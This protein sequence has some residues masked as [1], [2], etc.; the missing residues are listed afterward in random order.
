V[1]KKLFKMA[2]VLGLL[3]ASHAAYVRTF[4]HVVERLRSTQQVDETD[5]AVH[6]SETKTLVKET[7]ERVF[8]P[9]SWTNSD[10]LLRYVS[11][12]KG[13]ILFA[14]EFS[15]PVES[16]GVK[17]DGKRIEVT[18]AAVVLRSPKGGSTRT[19][20][21]ES[22]TIDFNKPFGLNPGDTEPLTVRYARLERNVMLRD[23]RGTP[24]DPSDDLVIGPLTE[25][26][27]IDDGLAPVIKTDSDVVVVDRN[28]RVTGT[29]L[30]I[31]LRPKLDATRPDG[32]SP[33][34]DGA[35]QL[36]LRKNVRTTFLDVGSTG[37]LPDL[38]ARRAGAAGAAK[39]KPE[40]IPLD[41]QCD[42]PL[43]VALPQTAPAPPVGPPQPA[44]PTYVEFRNNVVVRR[45]KL[46]ELPDQL[47]CDTLHLTLL[48]GE[49]KAEEAA[50]AADAPAKGEKEKDGA[51]GGL[52]LRRVKAS[53][54]AVWLQMPGQGAKILCV[55]LLHYKDPSSGKNT[56]VFNGGGPRKLWVEKA[57]L[58]AAAPAP[59]PGAAP[60]AP[61]SVT[62][63]WCSD[64]TLTDDG[65]PNR[66]TLV[67]NGP[68]LLETRPAPAANEPP[69]DVPPARTATWRDQLWVQ[70][71]KVEEGAVPGRILVLKG[72]P[73]V[74]DRDKGASLESADSIVVWLNPDEKKETTADGREVV[75]AAFVQPDPAAPKPAVPNI[76]RLLAVKDVHLIDPTRDLRLKDRLDVDFEAGT[77]QGSPAA[78]AANPA[79]AAK[80]AAS[81]PAGAPSGEPGLTPVPGPGAAAEKPAGPKMSAQ[82][83]RA[84]AVVAVV[85]AGGPR[86]AAPANS[87]GEPGYELREVE[88]RGAVALHQD[89]GPGKTVGTDAAGEVLILHNRAQGQ[90]VFDLYH[91]DQYSARGR[92]IDPKKAPKARV[93]TEE[94]AIEAD[95]ISVDQ[96][97]D[98]AW[99]Y[100]AGK[101]TQLTDRALF[102]DRSAEGL[103]EADREAGEPAKVRRRA[104]KELSNKVP[105][106]IT[107]A[108]EMNFEGIAKDPED[109]DA[110][111][112]RFVGRAHATMEDSLLYGEDSITVYT[113]KPI[114]LVDA[115][116]LTGRPA[117]KAEGAEPEPKADLSM[118]VV[119]GT[120]TQAAVATTRKVHPDLRL[121]L[122][123]QRLTARSL[124]YDRRTGVF[125]APGPG[126][127]YLYD[128]NS[129]STK[130]AGEAD[131][132][133]AAGPVVT[134]TSYRPG[135]DE[136]LGGG[137]KEKVAASPDAGRRAGAAGRPR[138][139]PLVLTQIEYQG[140]MRGRFGTESARTWTTSAGP[141][142]SGPCRRPG[143]TSPTRRGRSTT[144]G[145]RRPPRS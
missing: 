104:G 81:A 36:T 71:E 77:V 96:A 30:D 140:Q 86:P 107:W 134:P 42:G 130:P 12:E 68:G 95:T 88:M 40:S 144:T 66:A 124:T 128:R 20:T 110:A 47:T 89:P 26:E 83:E 60:A 4:D 55:E 41:V 97:A 34:F 5:F 79:P 1:L 122:S 98:K 94:M 120:E 25:V 67:A 31:Q 27:Y 131:A 91:H 145:C 51:F 108:D 43:V 29:G 52:T 39:A 37:M 23:D 78:A 58:A 100:G 126:R 59:A 10:D 139:A 7:A 13:V 115:G 45:G 32:R 17:F 14:A 16:G 127:A 143:G 56:T 44:D 87:A 8:G 22:A 138:R 50:A 72:S 19:M 84:R 15:R 2:T 135:E 21:S 70:N 114:P 93:T 73:K 11:P 117:P 48:P 75:P 121:T 62:H 92:A 111:K 35:Q 123:K 65:D 125:E 38:E 129:D 105:I 90:V 136:D 101:L 3:A 54:H 76:R 46:N 132:A 109:R 85:P 141:S 6:D 133:T 112:I 142:S 103:E 24:D 53:G 57:D 113:D 9:D 82:A 28:L 80:P 74:E 118:I 102:T 99:A 106:V 116:K 69:R 119:V 64:A 61:G 49:K 33:G 137:V 63:I 18:P